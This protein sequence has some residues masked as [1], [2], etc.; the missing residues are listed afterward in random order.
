MPLYL[1]LSPR[2]HEVLGATKSWIPRSPESHEVLNPTKF[3]IPRSPESHEVLNATKSS[4]LRSPHL[5]DAG[6]CGLMRRG[7]SLRT[8]GVQSLYIGSPVLVYQGSSPRIS[9]VDP[10]VS[11]LWRLK[12]PRVDRPTFI[13]GRVVWNPASSFSQSVTG[14]RLLLSVYALTP[15]VTPMTMDDCLLFC[16]SG[17]SV[18]S[19]LHSRCR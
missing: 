3:W 15:T 5:G 4:V 2:S 1:P 13:A 12:C 10:M 14:P 19:S 16:P 6:S 8:L 11:G 9:G 7:S 17:S 18:E